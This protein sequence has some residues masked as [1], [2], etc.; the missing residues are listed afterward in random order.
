MPLL[1]DVTKVSGRRNTRSGRKADVFRLEGVKA[2]KGSLFAPFPSGMWRS[3]SLN[4]AANCGIRDTRFLDGAD[5]L[6]EMAK[7][8]SEQGRVP[9]MTRPVMLTV[10]SL[11]ATP[12]G[13][14]GVRS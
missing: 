8:L 7:L 13:R 12:S 11:L 6:E 9:L 5:N 3:R 2:W 1:G 14:V 10:G 4:D